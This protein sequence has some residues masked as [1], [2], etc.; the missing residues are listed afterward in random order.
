MEKES[1]AMKPL[2]L[3]AVLL[4]SPLLLRAA[5]AS[6]AHPEEAVEAV[7]AAFDRV[8]V[9]ALGEAHGLMEQHE[10]LAS[11]LYHPEFARRVDTIIVEFG[12]ARYQDVL[13]RYLSGEAV[14]AAE[15]RQVWRD[16][17]QVLV[18]D[19]PIYQQFFALVRFV[20]RALPA[21]RRLR[22]LLG[23][24]PLDWSQVRTLEDYHRLYPVGRNQAMMSLVRDEVLANGRKALLIAGTFHVRREHLH[25][26]I[27]RHYPGST[28]VVMPHLDFG[29]LTA[30]QRQRL[31]QL[32]TAGPVLSLTR[33]RGTW[34]QTLPWGEGTWHTEMDAYLYLGPLASLTRSRPCS[35]IYRDDA[36]F[37]EVARRFEILH[38]QP[39]DRSALLRPQPER[40][41]P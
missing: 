2:L 37:R 10:F 33:I 21:S 13:D 19:A 22:V 31:E 25:Q 7:L 6:D 34:L 15:L 12:S 30:A 38:G 16:T 41:N 5:P 36:Y 8:P 24:P 1:L 14:P 17:S 3:A 4:V 9:V 35:D 11:L 29:D 27:E 18:W 39:L 23:D 32:L 26:Q 28:F 20:N 40:Y